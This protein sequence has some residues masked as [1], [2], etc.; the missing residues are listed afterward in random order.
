MYAKDGTIRARA[1]SINRPNLPE[2][3]DIAGQVKLAEQYGIPTQ[4]ISRGRIRR[5]SNGPR[6][7]FTLLDRNIA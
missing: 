2:R 3:D 6:L 7:T 4:M 5:T 1:I